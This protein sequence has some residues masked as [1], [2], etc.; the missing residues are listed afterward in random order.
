MTRFE[1]KHL[2]D[3]CG[4]Y[5][6]AILLRKHLFTAVSVSWAWMYLVVEQCSAEV[7]AACQLTRQVAV[8]SSCSDTETWQPVLVTGG[9]R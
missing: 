6:A 1:N 2:S 9:T 7:Q 4:T 3:N 8:V 5:F